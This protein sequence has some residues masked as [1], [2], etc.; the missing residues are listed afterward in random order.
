MALKYDMYILCDVACFNGSDKP[1]ISL[2]FTPLILLV[3][4]NQM[5]STY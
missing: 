5:E 1:Q 4:S 2:I 3:G